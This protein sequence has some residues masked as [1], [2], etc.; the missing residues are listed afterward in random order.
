MEIEFNAENIE[1]CLCLQCKV[2]KKS[3][4]VRDKVI[5]LQERALGSS[6]IEP[7]EFPALHCASGIEHCTDLD[8]KEEC[9]CKNCPIYAEN[10]L[11]TGTPTLYFCLDGSSASC[12][13]NEA[14]FDEGRVA[15]TLRD[16]YRRND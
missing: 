15:E 3:Q 14:K 8:R 6:L 2:Q 5:L 11:E 10:D 12:C 16:Y 13:L 9:L 1:K 7:K 4:C